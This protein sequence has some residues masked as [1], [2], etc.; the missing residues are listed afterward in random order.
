[1]NFLRLWCVAL[2]I[3]A[4]AVFAPL[5]PARA[6]G[7]FIAAPNRTDFVHDPARGL[8]YISSGSQILR[9]RIADKTFL[10]PF[11]IGKTV[12]QLD[13]APD[14]SFLIGATPNSALDG[15]VGFAHVDLNGG[16]VSDKWFAPGG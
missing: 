3:C 6:E 5:F 15:K 7:T 9:Y 1:M 16:I 8:I 2:F 12:R 13:L 14:G 11:E 10:P 4:L